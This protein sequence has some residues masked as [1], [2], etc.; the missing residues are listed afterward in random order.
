[1]NLS[2]LF[3]DFTH[4]NPDQAD[5]GWSGPNAIGRTIYVTT[6]GFVHQDQGFAQTIWATNTGNQSNWYG[7]GLLIAGAIGD[8]TPYRVKA[9]LQ[10]DQTYGFL[11]YG[12]APLAPAGVNDQITKL[13]AYPILGPDLSIGK[14]DDVILVPGLKEGDTDFGKPL[15]FGFGVVQTQNAKVSSY[16]SV[17]NLAKTAP[18]FAASMS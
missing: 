2:N 5:I 13:H 6:N 18:T 14:F 12:Y 15:F 7:S 10:A 9:Y 1:M 3:R 8:N 4:S 16:I 11:L 17:Q